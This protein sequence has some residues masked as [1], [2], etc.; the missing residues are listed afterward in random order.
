MMI[1]P[2]KRCLITVDD[3]LS[4][5]KSL[6][7]HGENNHYNTTGSL[8]R[9]DVNHDYKVMLNIAQLLICHC[10]ILLKIAGEKKSLGC[11]LLA[12]NNEP[13]VNK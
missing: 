12:V 6:A 13:V 8:L 2:E 9:S 4:I 1:A 3:W 7:N 11:R 5:G 10:L